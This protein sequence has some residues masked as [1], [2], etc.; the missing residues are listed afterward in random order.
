MSREA[1]EKMGET[2]DGG[3]DGHVLDELCGRPYAV[4]RGELLRPS[5]LE[6]DTV[7]DYG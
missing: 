4:N 6:Y 2:H 1:S 3:D 5:L 7:V